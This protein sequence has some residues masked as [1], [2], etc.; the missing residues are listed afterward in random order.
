MTAS[1]QTTPEVLTEEVVTTSETVS[2]E[3]L[4][5][6]LVTCHTLGTVQELQTQGEL[7]VRIVHEQK[8]RE[9]GNPEIEAIKENLKI[10]GQVSSSYQSND[11]LWLSQGLTGECLNLILI[12]EM[13]CNGAI[14]FWNSAG[15]SRSAYFQADSA[16]KSPFI[17]TGFEPR[18]GLSA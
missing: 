9:P 3:Q 10:I 14:N 16:I 15:F 12:G 18:A 1:P 13:P 8:E 11:F 4:G 17:L 5:I 7:E 2:V 6:Q